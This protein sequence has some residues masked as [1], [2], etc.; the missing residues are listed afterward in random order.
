M[1]SGDGNM[2][3]PQ[4]RIG[5]IGNSPVIIGAYTY[6][7]EFLTVCE[8][9]EGASL[10]IGRFCSIAMRATIFLGCEHRTDWATTFPFGHQFVNE[11]GG[12][13]IVGHPA[14]KGNVVIGN[15]VWLG[16]NSTI[17]SGV[18]VGDG[19]VIAANSH[20]AKN[21]APYEIVGGNPARHIKFRF[22]E[23]IRNLLT[24]LRWWDLPTDVIK[25]IAPDL[26]KEPSADLLNDLIHRFR[27][28]LE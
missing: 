18:W 21:V 16:Y 1:V 17:M 4:L 13:E 7:A 24:K 11:L 28:D 15:D 3:E 12:K 8:A 25:E 27:P 9:G 14:T 5:N 20:V 22:S 6:G 26:S 10:V 19:A 2:Q 23:E